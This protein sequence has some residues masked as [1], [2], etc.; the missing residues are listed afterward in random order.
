[1]SHSASCRVPLNVLCVRLGQGASGGCLACL[2]AL[3]D[4]LHR[5]GS[6]TIMTCHLPLLVAVVMR[7]QDPRSSSPMK[8]CRQVLLPKPPSASSRGVA[9]CA[10]IRMASLHACCTV[11]RCRMHNGFIP[12]CYSCLA[13]ILFMSIK[14]D[15]SLAYDDCWYTYP[16]GLSTSDEPTNTSDNLML[17]FLTFLVRRAYIACL[18][19]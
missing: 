17:G 9:L 12:W 2:L 7:G 16:D 13:M 3:T 6:Q 11:C 14:P 10:G 18:Y 1:M 8:A 5:E 15:Y 19:V 4:L